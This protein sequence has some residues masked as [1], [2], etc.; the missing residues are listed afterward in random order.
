MGE[1]RP[2]RPAARPI[3][4]FPAFPT[5]SL[6]HTP[7]PLAYLPSR[8]DGT[9]TARRP[10]WAGRPFG[11][12]GERDE[13]EER[14]CACFFFLV[15]GRARARAPGQCLSGVDWCVRVWARARTRVCAC[16]CPGVRVTIGVPSRVAPAGNEEWHSLVP[17]PPPVFFA[18]TLARGG[19]TLGAA[20]SARPPARATPPPPAPPLPPDRQAAHLPHPSG[21]PHTQSRGRT[22]AWPRAHAITPTA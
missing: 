1:P 4:P 17:A 11:D 2:R 10:V 13:E 12:G 21:L 9:G 18:L 6:F 8:T 16:V 3:T 19:F 14:L 15:S 22:G 20:P 7:T 5:S